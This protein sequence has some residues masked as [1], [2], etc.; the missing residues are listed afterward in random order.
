MIYESIISD[1]FDTWDQY[2]SD[3]YYEY[4]ES[5]YGPDSYVKAI[6]FMM[7]GEKVMLENL[8]MSEL[9]TFPKRTNYNNDKPEP[10]EHA[11][12]IHTATSYEVGSYKY[13][14]FELEGEFRPEFLIP[15]YSDNGNIIVSYEYDNPNYPHD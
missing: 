13:E 6:E 10:E 1:E 4:G 3:R 5:E 15:V 12:F 11:H 9:F 2:V 7:N 8:Q 14:E